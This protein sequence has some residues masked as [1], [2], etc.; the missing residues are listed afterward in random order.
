MN[1]VQS[2]KIT[3]HQGSVIIDLPAGVVAKKALPMIHPAAIMKSGSKFGGNQRLAFALA[4]MYVRKAC[5]LA[6]RPG[7]ID[8]SEDFLIYPKLVDIEPWFRQL[9]EASLDIE[10]TTEDAIDRASVIC[11]GVYDPH[12]NQALCIPFLKQFGDPYWTDDEEREVIRTIAHYAP[13]VEWTT[14][15]GFFDFSVLE[16]AGFPPFRWAWDTMVADIALNPELPH[17]LHQMATRY[18][19]TPYWKDEAKGHG[20]FLRIPDQQLRVYNLRDARQTWFI[21]LGQQADLSQE[22]T[23]DFR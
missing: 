4:T 5:D 3:Q 20:S 7:K 6:R 21:R 11:V 19:N 13:R 2:G 8:L 10:T 23:T 14:Q 22:V 15:N 9:R 12:R 17:R 1:L 16:T 18:T